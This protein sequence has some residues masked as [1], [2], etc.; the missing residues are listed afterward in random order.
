VD[1]VVSVQQV[2]LYQQGPYVVGEQGA[3]MFVPSTS[4]TIIPNNKLGNQVNNVS[5]TINDNG[6]YAKSKAIQRKLQNRLRL[7]LLKC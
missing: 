1:L 7:L 4:G 2:A 6:T 3:E 5:I